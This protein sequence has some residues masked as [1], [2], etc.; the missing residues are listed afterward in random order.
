MTKKKVFLIA[1]AHIDPMWQWEID[2]GMAAALSTFRNAVALAENNNFIF[3]HNEAM[4]Y[5]WIENNEPT[6]FERIRK[7]IAVGRWHIMGGWYLQPDCNMLSGESFIRQ[8]ETGK[9]YFREKFGVSPSVAINVDSFG[10]SVGMVQILAK[11]GYNGYIVGR[12]GD[13]EFRPGLSRFV[14]EGPDGS[15]VKVARISFYNTLLGQAAKRIE[16]AVIE[17]QNEKKLIFWGVGNHGGGPSRK[18]LTE[19]EKMKNRSEEFQYIHAYPEMFFEEIGDGLPKITESLHPSMPACYISQSRVKR[20]YRKLENLLDFT[21]KLSAACAANGREIQASSSIFEKAG[22]DLMLGQFHDVLPG[23]CIK[24]AEEDALMF[25][26][27]GITELKRLRTGLTAKLAAGEDLP[28]DSYAF[29]VFNPHPYEVRCAVECEFMLAD[30][31]HANYFTDIRM[32]CGD[33]EVPAQIIK[34]DSNIPLDWRKR[35]AFGARLKPM[36]ITAFYGVERHIEK[37]SF[38]SR[39]SIGI[40]DFQ[41]RFYKA[42]IDSEGYLTSVIRGT[43]E[44]LS[45]RISF[46]VFE[47]DEDTWGIRGQKLLRIGTKVGEYRLADRAE[48]TAL[49]GT[50]GEIGP[51]RIIEDGEV[52]TRIEA[53]YVYGRSHLVAQYTFYKDYDYIDLH[54]HLLQQNKNELLKLEFPLGE[55]DYIGEIPFGAETLVKG[56]NENVSLRWTGVFAE[57]R[58]FAVL[59]DGVYG[60]SFEEGKLYIS[61][62]RSPAYTGHPLGAGPVLLEDRFYPRVDQGELDFDFRFVFSRDKE[63]LL[64]SV[65][66]AAQEF[67]EKP[68]ALHMMPEGGEQS[69]SALILNNPE[70]VLTAFR[71]KENG[72]MLRFLNNC[73]SHNQVRGVFM[74]KIDFELCFAPFQAKTVQIYHNG[75]ME[76]KDSFID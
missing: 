48:S 24:R 27:H 71:Q 10:H 52:L 60:S 26:S 13:S 3:C 73:A 57:D 74:K 59:N 43:A 50:M 39:E 7:L 15:S 28:A 19:I 2:E 63:G 72:F 61:L 68:Y 8:I 64:R 37:R 55:G 67:N 33:E 76:E 49:S 45:G 35:I 40:I 41:N 36:G 70:I 44:F 69:C 66:S 62:T 51:I 47:D 31:N 32:F 38:A 21:E 20:L 53:V 46:S 11:C 54:V 30:Q 29:V 16:D 17:D 42:R 75:S 1:N 6:L 5:E 23:T 12:P 14:W 25:M 34:E 58:A 22:K 56:G 65:T 4:L 9:K 18:D